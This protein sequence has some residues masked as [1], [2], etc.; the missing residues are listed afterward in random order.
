MRKRRMAVLGMLAAV[1]LGGSSGG[2]G[3]AGT[4]SGGQELAPCP[5][6]PNC[7]SSLAEVE[8]QRVA[9]IAYRGDRGRARA[10]LVAVLGGMERVAITHDAGDTL[11]AEFRSAMF[12][13]V[14]DVA[15][16][17]A[18]AGQIQVRSASRAGYYDFG[19]NR[20]RVETIRARFADGDTAP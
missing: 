9:P 8:A 18:P 6:S 17:F 12:G 4:A 1:L 13:F 2:W 20:R 14:D 3:Q 5:D 16:R 10:R 7:V 11:R 19:V 15:F